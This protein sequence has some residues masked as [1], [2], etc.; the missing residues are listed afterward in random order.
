MGSCQ[1]ILAERKCKFA[2]PENLIRLA[3]SFAERIIKLKGKIL[4]IRLAT[5]FAQ[6][7]MAVKSLKF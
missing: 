2:E 7:I 5:S 1:P 3:T 6:R 4:E